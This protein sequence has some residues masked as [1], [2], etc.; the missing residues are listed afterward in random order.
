MSELHLDCEPGACPD[1]LDM[2]ILS[3]LLLGGAGANVAFGLY[4]REM[5]RRQVKRV[6]DMNLSTGPEQHGKVRVMCESGG[7]QEHKEHTV[8][9]SKKREE[10]TARLRPTEERKYVNPLAQ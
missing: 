8:T 5:A 4:M 2:S 7:V 10:T 1:T 3:T 9:Y 6:F